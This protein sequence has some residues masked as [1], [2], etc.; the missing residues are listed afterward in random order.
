MALMRILEAE[1]M[2]TP[3]DALEYDT[4]DFTEVNT[5]FATR[6]VDLA[7][8]V[9]KVLDIGTGT[10]RIPILMACR[11]PS[12][13]ITGI[14][15]SSNMLKVGD[16][17]VKREGLEKQITLRLVDAKSLPFQKG[18][19]DVVV[20]N[21]IVHHIPDPIP[22]FLELKR[23][24]VPRGVILIRD[25]LRPESEEQLN[26]TVARVCVNDTE[27]QTKLFRDS[28]HAAFTLNEVCQFASAAGLND[29]TIYQSSDRHWTLER[30]GSG[31]N[32]SRVG[33]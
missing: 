10:A 22:F 32:Q 2:D 29:V 3:E 14:D 15:L 17:N 12:W 20:S 9:A 18:E 33:E 4:M 8:E 6:A 5:A 30:K 28:L 16:W 24:L 27:Y 21:S 7:S 11:R 25:L 31:G 1:V 23:V 13:K 19:F 26:E